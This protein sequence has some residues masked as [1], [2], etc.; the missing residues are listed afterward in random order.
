MLKKRVIPTLL[1]KDNKLVK[2]KNFLSDRP[3]SSVIESVKM[4]NIRGVDELIFHDIQAT[5]KKEEPNYSLISD[6]S[7]ECFMPLV[8]G[9]GITNLKVIEKLL[10]VGADKVSI[11]SAAVLNPKFLELASKEFGS[12]CIIA[13]IDYKKSI[14]YKIFICSGAKETK[15]DLFEIS[16]IFEN[17]GCGEIMI[18]SIDHDGMQNGYDLDTIIKVKN[19]IKTPLICSGG[20]GTVEDMLEV[21]KN[22]DIEALAAASIFHFSKITPNDAKK[23]LKKEGINVRT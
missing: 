5:K 3:V 14:N 11:N 4:Y 9:G 10:R 22:T 7:K 2:G 6:I 12:Q 1:Y 16:K 23:I 20:C 19:L 15:H 18:C 17:S 13:S 21:F 8:I